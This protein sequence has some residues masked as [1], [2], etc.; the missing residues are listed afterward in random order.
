MT[1]TQNDIHFILKCQVIICQIYF[2]SQ[3]YS[4]A[5]Y[6]MASCTRVLKLHVLHSRAQQKTNQIIKT[7]VQSVCHSLEPQPSVCH[8]TFGSTWR[9]SG[10]SRQT[11]AAPYCVWKHSVAYPASWYVSPRCTICQ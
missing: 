10:D 2:L 9:S 4:N 5:Q 11:A 7:T 6:P 8:V 3:Y 1:L